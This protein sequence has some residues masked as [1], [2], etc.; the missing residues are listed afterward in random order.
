MRLMS[1][2]FLLII[3]VTSASAAPPSVAITE[4]LQNLRGLLE[5]TQKTKAGTYAKDVIERSK[6]TLVR[7]QLAAE[8]GNELLA[9]QAFD[10]AEL[11]IKFA[12][13]KADEREASELSATRRSEL[14]VI[15]TQVDAYLQ[16]REQ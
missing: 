10:I 8:S 1:V 5:K 7:G 6:D 2:L 3:S 14:K 11:L 13:V 15:E 12:S 16:G 9:A 4:R